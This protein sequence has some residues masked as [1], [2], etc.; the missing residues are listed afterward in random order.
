MLASD[1]PACPHCTSSDF[2]SGGGSFGTLHQQGFTCKECAA[3]VTTLFGYGSGVIAYFSADQLGEPEYE[4]GGRTSPESWHQ[5]ANEVL[6]P[7]WRDHSAKVKACETAE[8]EA[9]LEEVFFPTFP[10]YVGKWGKGTISYHDIS[11]EAQKLTDDTFGNANERRRR[12]VYQEFPPEL[13]QGVYPP[14]TP[15]QF[16]MFYMGKTGWEPVDHVYSATLEVP[17]DPIKKNSRLLFEEI[18]K[19]IPAIAFEDV[20]KAK[21]QYGG[22]ESWYT[23]TV[24]HCTFTTGWRK[25]V[26]SIQVETEKGVHTEEIRAVA[27]QDR[28]TY[29]A[30]GPL[31]LLTTEKLEADLRASAEDVSEDTIKMIVD[32]HRESHPDGEITREGGWQ[33]SRSLAFA[34]EV[35]AWGKAKAIEYLEILTRSALESKAA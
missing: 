25:R 5:W 9:W 24:G 18:F 30:R 7:T 16:S 21:N 4:G 13:L 3:L 22:I 35:H 34:L 15:S 33:D 29:T 20:R 32:G 1:I 14:Q 27:T 23:F 17:E 10:E 2:R 8:W 31:V 12:G 26:I 28:T 19:S 6:L 11:P